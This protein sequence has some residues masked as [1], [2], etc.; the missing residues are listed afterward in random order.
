[1]H[2]LLLNIITLCHFAVVCFVV[3]TPFIGNNYFLLM[4]AIL[5]PFIMFHWIINDNTCVLSTIE[6]KIREKMTN[7]TSES[8]MDDCFTCKL[9]NPIYDFRANYNTYSAMIYIVTTLLWLVSVYKIYCRLK[10]GITLHN[11]IA[12]Q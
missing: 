2:N 8:A 12:N 9:I 1:M 3:L 10:S 7:K 6:K 11:M 5:V 4:H